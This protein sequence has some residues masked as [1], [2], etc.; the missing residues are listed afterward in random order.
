M[1]IRISKYDEGAQTI[2]IKP[3]RGEPRPVVVLEGVTRETLRERVGPAI[4]GMLAPA[5]SPL[6]RLG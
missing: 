4:G 1:R 3:P 5:S 2:I 6:D